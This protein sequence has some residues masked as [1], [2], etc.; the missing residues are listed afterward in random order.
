[1][2]H[3]AVAGRSNQAI[4]LEGCQRRVVSAQRD[5][6][7]GDRRTRHDQVEVGGPSKLALIESLAPRRDLGGAESEIGVVSKEGQDTLGIGSVASLEFL[8]GYGHRVSASGGRTPVCGLSIGTRRRNPVEGDGR[9]G[10]SSQP[11]SGFLSE[12]AAVP[13][14][15]GFFFGSAIEAF[16][17]T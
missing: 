17:T 2:R 13:R 1:M 14:L 16:Q 5:R 11:S 12:F 6:L 8:A 9:G 3:A 4:G 7:D 10:L 15:A